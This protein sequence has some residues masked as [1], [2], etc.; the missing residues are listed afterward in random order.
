MAKKQLIKKPKARK[1]SSDDELF[2]LLIGEEKWEEKYSTPNNGVVWFYRT[3]DQLE[4]LY[5]REYDITFIDA[6]LTEEQ[7][8]FIDVKVK[9]HRCFYTNKFNPQKTLPNVDYK[10]I[11]QNYT[12]YFIRK[13]MA[14]LL[15]DD[16]IQGFL[17]HMINQYFLV[18]GGT[19]MTPDNLT[20]FVPFYSK[21]QFQGHV[22]ASITADFGDEYNYLLNWT[23]NIGLIQNRTLELWLEFQKTEGIS[24]ILH[25]DAIEPGINPYIIESFEFKDEE[26][27][28]PIIIPRKTGYEIYSASLKIKGQG[29]LKLGNLHYRESRSGKGSFLVG[30][31][32][33]IDQVNEEFVSY[34]YPGDLKPPLTVY[35][36]G[37]R[38]G[39][40]FEGE[41]MMKSFGT[42]YLLI[43]DLRLEGGAFYRGNKDYE[44]KI[45]ATIQK[46]LDWLGFSNDQLI[47]S[48]ISMGTFGALYYGMKMQP[49]AI[50]VGKPL[51]NLGQ[52]A[53]NETVFRPGGFPTS[54]DLLS[55]NYGS[56]TQ[57]N[58]DKMDAYFWD[59]FDRTEFHGMKI[60]AAYMNQDDYDHTA[61]EDLVEHKRDKDIVIYGKGIEGRHNDNTTAIVQWFV[62]Q[63]KE[64]MKH[65]FGREFES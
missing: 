25:V 40:G 8:K 4:P 51:I 5:E 62:G 63:Y 43:A 6:P 19:R 16:E 33:T 31:Q 28:K 32:K 1:K 18:V 11:E 55:K 22:Y 2:I 29:T 34:F 57:E 3:P 45:E 17:D 42:P 53:T 49:D 37:Y 47:L 9:P 44:N 61:Y 10:H 15:E 12:N 54:L 30:G 46:T 24:V 50:I 14:E 48:G 7:L 60:A 20:F 59:V 27:E 38:T 35:F 58:A 36:S 52:M 56:M 41:Y 13:K 64:I 23:K 21:I 26:L 39:E 65:D